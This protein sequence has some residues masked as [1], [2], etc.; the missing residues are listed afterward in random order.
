M[1]KIMIRPLILA[2]MSFSL[3]LV[4]IISLVMVFVRVSVSQYQSPPVPPINGVALSQPLPVANFVLQDQHGVP[5]TRDNLLGKWHI[6][7][8]GYTHCPDICPLTLTVLTR[9]AALLR[10]HDLINE[11]N[12]IFYTVDPQR[13]SSRRL[14]EY[15]G[16]FDRHIIGLRKSDDSSY[17]AFEKSLNI[18][19]IYDKSPDPD[20]SYRVSHGL[21]LMIVNP[22]GTLQAILNPDIDPFG[23]VSLSATQLFDDFERVR[24]SYQK[25][26]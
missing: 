8:Y 11:V 3:L 13:D 26:V 18:T 20:H 14:A 9:L 4:V 7:A 25:A 1:K 12:L 2:A 22:E 23:E 17:Q 10:S 24:N 19:A 6:V 5:F 15:L 16:Y 21:R